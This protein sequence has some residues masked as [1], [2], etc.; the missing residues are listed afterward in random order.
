LLV[1]PFI[2]QPAFSPIFLVVNGLENRGRFD[3]ETVIFEPTNELAL[4][5]FRQH[6]DRF[7]GKIGPPESASFAQAGRLEDCYHS[8]CWG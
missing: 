5:F 6:F 2:D 7:L 4:V 8:L 3:N 1:L